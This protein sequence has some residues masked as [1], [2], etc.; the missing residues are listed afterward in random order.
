MQPPARRHD[1]R[2][3]LEEGGL[4]QAALVVAFLVPGI[5]EEDQ[6]LV[7]RAGRQPARDH[8]DSVVPCDADIS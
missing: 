2:E 5:R 3:L 7:D 8:L 4:H 1:A 6:R